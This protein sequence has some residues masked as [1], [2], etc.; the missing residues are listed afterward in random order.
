MSDFAIKYDRTNAEL[1]D[2]FLYCIAVAGKSAKGQRTVL[3]RFLDEAKSPLAHIRQLHK[4][5]K[6]I[7][8]I[9]KAKLAPYDQFIKSFTYIAEHEINLRTCTEEELIKIPR[10]RFKTAKLFL[11]YSRKGYRGAILDRHILAELRQKGFN[12][13]KNTPNSIKKYKEIET[14]V[15]D[16]A[17]KA[18]VD[19]I[20]LDDYI[21]RS[22][23]KSGVPLTIPQL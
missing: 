22:R 6:L 18:R 20:R 15:L 12:V 13:P 9:Y 21:W 1:E 19:P 17:D 10:I 14:I 2:W 11:A 16:W 23:N 8:A 3:D 5:N 7:D 4:N